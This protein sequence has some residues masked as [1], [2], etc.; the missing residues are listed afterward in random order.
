MK[1]KYDTA[2]Q[3]EKKINE[4]FDSLISADPDEKDE[5]A[6]FSG[7]AYYLGFTRRAALNEYA[8]RKDELSVPIKRAMLRIESH[9]EK[10]LNKQSCTGAIFALKNRGWT[11]KK[12]VEHSGTLN[13]NIKSWG[14]VMGGHG[15]EAE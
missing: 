2:E 6:T 8:A 3:L 10:Q 11:D 7:L 5:P 4:Y 13:H 9:Y 14:E 1:R 12:D 15:P